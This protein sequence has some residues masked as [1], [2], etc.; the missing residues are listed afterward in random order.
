MG[1]SLIAISVG[2]PRTVEWKGTDVLTSIFKEQVEGRIHL[3][4]LNL[5]G[6]EQADLTVHGGEFKAVY[7][8]PAEHYD[9]WRA[10]A[11][12]LSPILEAWGAFGENFT[13]RGLHEDEVH[14]GDRFRL[15]AAE[16]QVTEPRMPCAKVAVRFQRKDMTRRF[17]RSG[18]T[19]FYVRVLQEGDVQAGDTL[20]FLGRVESSVPVSTITGLFTREI[21]DEAVLRQAAGL[22]VLPES[23]RAY[24]QKRLE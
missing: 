3:A 2:R 22:E 14:I 8:Y 13:T 4:K 17:L 5:A 18:R 12:E 6:D 16:V 19:G 23:W 7:V 1:A 10:E 9:F 21:T 24:F 20:D 15:G 11:P